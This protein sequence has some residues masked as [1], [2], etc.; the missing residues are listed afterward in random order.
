M[1]FK[2]F[3][4][5]GS[6]G[7][8]SN[9]SICVA[10]LTPAVMIAAFSARADTWKGKETTRE[11]VVHI[12]NPAQP[13]APPA[14]LSPELLWSAGG[15]DNEDYFFG[16]L[17]G[18][19]ADAAGNI[20]L[21]DAQLNEV[22]VFSPDGAYLRSIGREGEGPGEFQR[23]A[24]MFLTTD[25][26]IAVV[27]R[28]PGKIV[29]LTPDG[30]PAGNFP[31]PEA[32][33]GGF[34]MFAGGRLAGESVVLATMQFQ[35][36][37]DGMKEV[38]ALIGVNRS[39]ARTAEYLA[40]NNTRNFANMVFNERDLNLNTLV[41]DAAMDGSVY[42][43][44]DFDAYRIKIFDPSGA[45]KRVVER[46]YVLRERS[47]EERER[48]KPR[49]Q[50]RANN[51]SMSPEA[52]AS[53]TDRSVVRVYPRRDGSLWV[54]SSHGAF[55]APAGVIGTFDV[56]DVSG[57]FT[58]QVTVK[59]EGNLKDDGI[60]IIGN[61]LYVIKGLRSARRAMFAA[62]DSESASDTD[63]EPVTVLCYDLGGVK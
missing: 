60:E 3:G 48:N 41:W 16:V 40:M 57:K 38:S 53:K 30:K 7:V 39:G 21:L 33:D 42:I 1:K 4:M 20:Y 62:G 45:L 24:D 50:I 63:A 35:R 46:E 61:R 22:M 26:N 11:G 23:P 54:L 8:T 19:A 27:Q 49:I 10:L 25:G 44:D 18:I 32:A 55:D 29:L 58:S 12:M 56:Y 13:V 51:R 9:R 52:T 59:G 37:D 15:D 47:E 34:Q 6:N 2:R 17:S 36:L 31:V 43:S 14:T 28:M 5:R